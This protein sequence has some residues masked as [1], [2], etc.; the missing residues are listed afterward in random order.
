MNACANV[1]RIIHLLV[2]IAIFISVFIP[3]RIFKTVILILLIFIII[4]YLIG[5]PICILTKLEYMCMG[6]EYESGFVYRLV[7]PVV[8]ITE[9]KIAH[10]LIFFK[11][12]WIV[13][14][15]VQ[16]RYFTR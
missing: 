2:L 14:L 5:I 8:N 6:K 15:I 1:V 3:N 9:K 10:G 13:I 7:N 12:I 16:L 11:I 4:Q